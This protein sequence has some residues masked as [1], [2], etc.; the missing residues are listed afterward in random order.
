M[1]FSSE[2]K[3]NKPRSGAKKA[4]RTESGILS[5]RYSTFSRLGEPPVPVVR[6]NNSAAG[7]P[8]GKEN[9]PAK[10]DPPKVFLTIGSHGHQNNHR[11]AIMSYGFKLLLRWN[12][13]APN[14]CAS[15]LVTE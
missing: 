9:G 15:W 10:A 12:S 2:G 5:G 13:P 8:A 4:E 7:K 1:R 14:F 6:A 11:E 3:M